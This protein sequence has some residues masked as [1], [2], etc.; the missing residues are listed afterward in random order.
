MNFSKQKI[1]T[2]HDVVGALM[3]LSYLSYFEKEIGTADLRIRP[4]SDTRQ[5]RSVLHKEQGET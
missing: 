1:C 4:D 2:V 5:Q 3:V